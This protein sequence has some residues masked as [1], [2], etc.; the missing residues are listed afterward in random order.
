MNNY[1]ETETEEELSQYEIEWLQNNLPESEL[2]Q[3]EEEFIK[4]E[5]EYYME[6]RHIN[7]LIK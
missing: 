1:T 6:L 2:T 4:E 7:N 5:K 3:D